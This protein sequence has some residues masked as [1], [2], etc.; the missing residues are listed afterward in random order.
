[1]TDSATAASAEEPGQLF[2]ALAQARLDH[3]G[4]AVAALGEEFLDRHLA[5]PGLER[6]G[7][8]GR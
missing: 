3:L 8:R 4:I 7:R 2:A 5:Q 6:P 1:M